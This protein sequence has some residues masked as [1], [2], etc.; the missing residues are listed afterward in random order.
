M[1]ER[2]VVERITDTAQRW[3]FGSF[4]ELVAF[5]RQEL[6]SAGEGEDAGPET[7]HN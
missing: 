4:D 1:V 7:Q 6:L 2:F 5:L 3:V